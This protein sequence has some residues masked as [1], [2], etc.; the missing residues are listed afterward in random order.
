MGI[1][2][3][4]KP[5]TATQIKK[6]EDI[7]NKKILDIAAAMIKK[8]FYETKEIDVHEKISNEVENY[9]ENL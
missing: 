2:Q 6:K 1:S 4:S 7:K 3:F 9:I 8:R 5:A